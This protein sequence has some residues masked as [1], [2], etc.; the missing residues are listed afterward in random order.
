MLISGIKQSNQGT[1]YCKINYE[2]YQKPHQ[3]V[4]VYT[5]IVLSNAIN[6]LVV[7]DMN[8]FYLECDHQYLVKALNLTNYTISWFNANLIK[9][10][11]NSSNL[12]IKSSGTYICQIRDQS[13]KR[14]WLINMARIKVSYKLKKL[15]SDSIQE[16][17]YLIT[18]VVVGLIC[19]LFLVVK[20]I[21]TKMVLLRELTQSFQND[22]NLKIK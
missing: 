5:L 12:K 2:L 1:Y 17:K 14:K 4:N 15:I 10:A 16:H 22:F 7:I 9:I 6:K 20:F 18:I 19:N 3:F 13:S 21:E 8:D 11:L